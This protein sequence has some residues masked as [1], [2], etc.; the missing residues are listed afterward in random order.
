MKQRIPWARNHTRPHPIKSFATQATHEDDGEHG[1][2]KSLH[3][4]PGEEGGVRVADELF[5]PSPLA[6]RRVLHKH[7]KQ[8]RKGTNKKGEGKIRR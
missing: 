7:T 1:D 5:Q 8:T 3:G 2:N 6:E 4:L